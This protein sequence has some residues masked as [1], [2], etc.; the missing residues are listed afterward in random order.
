LSSSSIGR[1]A[2]WELREYLERLGF[3]VIR[4]AASRIVDLIAI[5][6]DPPHHELFIEV[7]ST[8]DR[9]FKISRIRANGEQIADLKNYAALIEAVLVYCVK[10][11]SE[12]KWAIHDARS[13]PKVIRQEDARALNHWEETFSEGTFPGIVP[14]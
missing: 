14:P 4:S 2:E 13:L 10:F 9:N 3:L 1:D 6:M 5:R 12:G 7:K 11:R 8:M